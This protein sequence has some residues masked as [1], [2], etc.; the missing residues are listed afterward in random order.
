M[1]L[2]EYVDSLDDVTKSRYF[3]KLKALGLAATDDPY[4]SGDLQ[5]AIRLW[6]PVEFGHIF[7]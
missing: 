5:N 2:R 6:P 3:Y 7:C 4:A 1:P